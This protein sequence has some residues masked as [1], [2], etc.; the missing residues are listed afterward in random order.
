MGVCLSVCPE[1]FKMDEDCNCCK[2]MTL[3]DLGF[4]YFPFLIAAFIWTLI[5]VFGLLKTKAKIQKGRRIKVS[6]QNT[7]TSVLIGVAG[8]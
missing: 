6:S 3:M 4:I 8:L 5:C 7:V 1:E 2:T